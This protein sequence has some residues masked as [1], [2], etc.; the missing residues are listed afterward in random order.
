MDQQT[1]IRKHLFDMLAVIEHALEAVERQR[2]DQEVR[3]HVDAN[4]ILI[5]LERVLRAQ[6]DSLQTL[7][8]HYGAAG[9]SL[10]K[11]AMSEAMGLVAGLYDRVRDHRVSRMLRDDYVA[12]S[13]AAMSYTALHAFGLAIHDESLAQVALRHLE[14]L[15]PLMVE[16][17]RTIPGLVV[18]EVG[19]R[20]DK[21]VDVDAIQAAVRNTQRAWEM[22]P[23][24]TG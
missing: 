2:V 22:T 15:T 20:L 16:I 14:D 3:E 13:L 10:V 19:D 21:R 9:E 8:T 12:L 24:R 6:R 1:E 17:S 18:S 4:S 7:A 5:E 11:K 23:A